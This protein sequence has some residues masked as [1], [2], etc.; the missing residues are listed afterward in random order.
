MKSLKG[1][2]GGMMP[3]SYSSLCLFK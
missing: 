2:A 3:I 1:Q